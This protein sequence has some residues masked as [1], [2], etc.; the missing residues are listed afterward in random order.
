MAQ[1]KV[2]LLEAHLR[3]LELQE[4]S[5]RLFAASEDSRQNFDQ[6]IATLESEYEKRMRQLEKAL[7]QA[8]GS[9]GADAQASALETQRTMNEARNK[10]EARLFRQ[11]EMEERLAERETKLSERERRLD[12][13]ERE[14]LRTALLIRKP[15]SHTEQNEANMMLSQE[16]AIFRSQLSQARRQVK[17][18]EAQLER[19]ANECVNE[20]VHCKQ[21]PHSIEMEDNEVIAASA[22]PLSVGKPSIPHRGAGSEH[23]AATALKQE[24]EGRVAR[25]TDEVQRSNDLLRNKDAEFKLLVVELES[26]R[27]KN[28]EPPADLADGEARDLFGGENVSPNACEPPCNA[29]SVPDLIKNGQPPFQEYATSRDDDRWRG[30]GD[31]DNGSPRKE[32]HEQSLCN[33]TCDLQEQS[34]AERVR[35]EFQRCSIAA[36]ERQLLT[37]SFRTL[38]VDL[39][40]QPQPLSEASNAVNR[41]LTI[42]TPPAGSGPAGTEASQP[43]SCS[44][45]SLDRRL[46]AFRPRSSDR[47]GGPNNSTLRGEQYKETVGPCRSSAPITLHETAS[48]APLLRESTSAGLEFHPVPLKQETSGSLP[49]EITKESEQGATVDQFPEQ[50]QAPKLDQCRQSMCSS[51]PKAESTSP[52]GSG[53]ESEENENKEYS[54]TRQ[55]QASPQNGEALDASNASRSGQDVAAPRST[56]R[57]IPHAFPSKDPQ[58]ITVKRRPSVEGQLKPQGHAAGPVHEGPSTVRGNDST[59]SATEAASRSPQENP[60]GCRE[61]PVSTPRDCCGGEIACSSAVAQNIPLESSPPVMHRDN[62]GFTGSRL[63]SPWAEA[64]IASSLPESPQGLSNFPSLSCPVAATIEGIPSPTRPKLDCSGGRTAAQRKS[65]FAGSL[66]PSSSPSEHEWLACV[67]PTN[68]VIHTNQADSYND[69]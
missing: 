60:K 58:T 54:S 43:M 14:L 66:P 42:L 30:W 3:N 36:A 1:S 32:V 17:L 31:L 45:I 20:G 19:Q 46:P 52:L 35:P 56:V 40:K 38:S 55:L 7:D 53:L 11:K 59:L 16:N 9:H 50:Q 18:L 12:E 21:P 6:R 2:L 49:K 39:E 41:T 23:A 15:D 62:E 13:K 44:Q 47:V 37:S 68:P 26:A 28:A 8:T 48:K 22:R 10:L 51:L 25:L 5:K 65:T 63:Q 57:G 67:S 34:F 24:Y 4:S 61:T 27:R 29:G 69:T 33:A 64:S